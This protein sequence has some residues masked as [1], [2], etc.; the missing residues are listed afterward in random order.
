MIGLFRRPVV[1][2]GGV[3]RPL[4]ELP[5]LAPSPLA[6]SIVAPASPS[7]T[8]DAFSIGDSARDKRPGFDA[9]SY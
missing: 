6:E 4:A 5:R 1:R 3:T 9:A 7:P 2:T 8:K